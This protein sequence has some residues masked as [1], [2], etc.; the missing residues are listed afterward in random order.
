MRDSIL[1][2]ID[3]IAIQAI[4]EKAT[5]GCV[6]TVIQNGR[7]AYQKAFGALG[8]DS[9]I[10]VT[11]N[12]IYDL[13]SVTK[14]SATTIAIMKL[15]EEGKL[16]VKDSISKFLPWL[17]GSN[18]Q[19]LLVENLL[20]HQAGLS[21]YTQ[22]NKE[23]LDHGGNP[24]PEFTSAYK[25]APFTTTVTNS[26]YLRNDWNDTMYH[27][28]KTSAVN[29]RELKYVY[30][31]NDFIL[32]AKIIQAVTGQTLDAYM[33]DNFYKPLGMST[34]RFRPFEHFPADQ[35]APTEKEKYFRKELVWNYVHD[36]GAAMFDNVSGHAGLFSNG[37]DLAILYQ[38][39]L[40]GGVYKGKRYL[41][42]ETIDWFTSYQT[43][44]SRRGLGFDK[45][46]KDNLIKPLEKAYPAKSVS[47]F[48]FGHTGFTGTCVWVDPKYNLIYIFLSNR[49]NPSAENNL[50]SQTNVRSRIQEVIYKALAPASQ[51]A[52]MMRFK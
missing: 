11:P 31:D 46:E 8:Y 38:M 33:L 32:L 43:P 40:N 22:F 44:I 4:H 1:N 7:L 42:K 12:T 15:V 48:T 17:T 28:I 24:L 23:I 13:A 52:G 6:V 20:L 36:P 45:P 26:L 39:L 25:Q 29:D 50:L 51:E 10:P 3:S 5:P 9:L 34:T 49:V 27:R 18:K 37:S 14:I 47:P 30:S 21:P 35:V 41:N 19:N 16:S 2:E